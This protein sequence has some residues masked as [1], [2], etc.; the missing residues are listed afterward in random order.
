N[1][2]MIRRM[3]DN[4]T[5]EMFSLSLATLTGCSGAVAVLLTDGTFA[6]SKSRKL[7]GGVTITA[8]EHHK[9]C[10][11]GLKNEGE[12]NFSEYMRT[13]A[14]NIMKYGVALGKV[15]W[16][17]FLDKIQCRGE[18]INKVIC[19][20]VGEANQKLILKTL[21]I[22]LE[23]D[24]STFPYLGNMGTCSLPITAAIAKEREFMHPGDTVGF[25]GIGSGLNCMMMAIQW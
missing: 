11:W 2:I 23:N 17:A 10:N 3:L 24:F 1:E 25:L 16:D 4:P 5:M 6:S 12:G 13:D 8:P 18:E 22:P 14:V 21:G 15:T 7:V 20:Q 9:L 19:H